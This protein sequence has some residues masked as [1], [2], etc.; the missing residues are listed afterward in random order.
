MTDDQRASKRVPFIRDIDIVGVGKR[1]TMDLSVGGMYIEMVAD[2][3]TG[4]EFELRFKL[5][6]ADPDEIRVRARVLYIHPGI[7]AGVSFLNLSAQNEE[8]IRKWIDR[9]SN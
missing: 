7:G 9:G 8:K 6:D 4:A 2:F 3:Q 1:R 5:A